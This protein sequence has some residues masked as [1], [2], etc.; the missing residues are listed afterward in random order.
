MPVV[1]S[2]LLDSPANKKRI[3][4]KRAERDDVPRP[5]KKGKR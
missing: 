4:E 3:E 5:H 1:K 2:R